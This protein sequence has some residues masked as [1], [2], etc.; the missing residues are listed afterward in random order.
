M[1]FVGKRGGEKRVFEPDKVARPIRR[2]L[3]GAVGIERG[4]RLELF[5]KSQS[6]KNVVGNFVVA[7]HEKKDFVVA[8][9]VYPFSVDKVVLALYELFAVD[10]FVPHGEVHFRNLR[11][12]ERVG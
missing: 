10:H 12:R 8:V 4:A 6:R 2:S 3:F 7:V 11:R 5:F 1:F 9:K